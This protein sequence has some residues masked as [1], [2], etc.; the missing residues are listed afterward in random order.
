MFSDDDDMTMEDIVI[1][2]LVVVIFPFAA[3]ATSSSSDDYSLN[4]DIKV[5]LTCFQ[6]ETND[7]IV[8][9]LPPVELRCPVTL[10]PDDKE[11][12][13]RWRK[14]GSLIENGTGRWISPDGSLHLKG[15]DPEV[16]EGVYECLVQHPVGTIASRRI[17]LR[18]PKLPEFARHPRNGVALL[19]GSARFECIASGAPDPAIAWLKDGKPLN[20]TL[21][22]IDAFSGVLHIGELTQQDEGSYE[23]QATNAAGQE[24]SRAAR[25]SISSSNANGPVTPV[26]LSG[27]RDQ[28]A[29]EFNQVVFECLLTGR[30]RPI[31]TWTKKDG[32]VFESSGQV[33]V[34]HLGNLVISGVQV[35]DSGI[36]ICSW[37]SA[38]DSTSRSSAEA[39]LVVLA[40][41]QLLP[42]EGTTEWLVVRH[43]LQVVRLSCDFYGVPPPKIVWLKNGKVLEPTG[44]IQVVDLELII[45][46]SR[47]NDSGFYQCRAENTVGASHS[48]TWV[49][50]EIN[51]N[52]PLPPVGLEAVPLTSTSIGLTW[53]DHPLS[54]N[55]SV[56][57]YSVHSFRTEDY[58]SWYQHEKK[59]NQVVVKKTDNATHISWTLET[60]EPFTNYTFYVMAYNGIGGSYYSNFAT[61]MTL[62]DVPR[63]SP[64]TEIVTLGSNALRVRWLALSQNVARGIVLQYK[65]L[66]RL[67]GDSSYQE[68][69]LNAKFQEFVIQGLGPEKEY[70]VTVVA[71]TK[72]GFTPLDSA[73]WVT[74]TTGAIG[75]TG[76]V[77]CLMMNISVLISSGLLV[78]WQS[79]N[80]SKLFGF[81]LVFQ[82][83]GHYQMPEDSQSSKVIIDLDSEADKYIFTQLEASASYQVSLSSQS[84]FGQDCR[85]TKTFRV[86]FLPNGDF[87]NS[88][89]AVHIGS[90]PAPPSKISARAVNSS[91]IY[92]QWERPQTS[93]GPVVR[94]TVR[95]HPD[96]SEATDLSVVQLITSQTETIIIGGLMAYTVYDLSVQSHTADGATGPFSSARVRCRTEE[97]VPSKPLDVRLTLYSSTAVQVL[98]NPPARRNG[99]IQ[100]YVIYYSDDSSRLL[101]KWKTK[102]SGGSSLSSLVSHLALNTVFYFCLRAA[103]SVGEGRVSDVVYIQ[104]QEYPGGS[105]AELAVTNEPSANALND[106]DLGIIIGTAIGVTCIVVCIIII[107]IR[108]RRCAASSVP[109]NQSLVGNGALV[110]KS[111]CA[112]LPREPWHGADAED[113]EDFPSVNS[114]LVENENCD[115]KGGYAHG[116]RNVNIPLRIIAGN[117]PPQVNGL[118]LPDMHDNKPF[119]PV[120]DV[121]QTSDDIPNAVADDVDRSL[122]Q[123]NVQNSMQYESHGTLN[124]GEKVTDCRPVE[125]ADGNRT[126]TRGCV[127]CDSDGESNEGALHS[128]RAAVLEHA[129]SLLGSARRDDSNHKTCTLISRNDSGR[130]H[131][132]EEQRHE[133]DRSEG[134]LSIV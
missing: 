45:S 28:T 131:A 19:G 48:V 9:L 79:K 130:S 70:D 97:G 89:H 114:V 68:D 37:T 50:I 94:Y 52:V 54:E 38:G 133:V 104:T 14:D 12:S 4:L 113:E 73:S 58:S 128:T 2:S 96:T 132:R 25:L 107:I 32:G 7:V 10:T 57:A 77:D 125:A 71:A 78:S 16:E 60:L 100:N 5:L 1:V 117:P 39:R 27:P 124:L 120:S 46:S 43:R 93:G 62:Q 76:A 53:N 13:I 22:R 127:E 15:L 42:G 21:P 92:V 20:I 34:T 44:R 119:I 66:H 80:A 88:L 41:P 122:E 99:V 126:D 101:S 63:D 75:K 106:L 59:E 95:Y 83:I 33:R 118:H 121:N 129:E 61:A 49:N 82:K 85:I 109:P 112:H 26:L 74:V 90:L 18:V 69:V 67:H 84:E 3:A 23:C 102:I 105:F 56:I 134:D 116:G 123:S 40:P 11:I 29:L 55:R 98:W 103:T 86:D 51:E 6:N 8:Y 111:C 17:H 31:V 36:Y 108:D 91:A 65:I 110:K 115:T 30:P 87:Q 81:R 47:T 24:T 72:M 35:S 64:F